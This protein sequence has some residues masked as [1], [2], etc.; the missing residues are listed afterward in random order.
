MIMPQSAGMYYPAKKSISRIVAID[1]TVAHV[2]PSFMSW[3]QSLS[4]VMVVPRYTKL[5]TYFI[6]LPF[7]RSIS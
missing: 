4:H 6:S 1:V 2:N 7:D 5:C 3:V